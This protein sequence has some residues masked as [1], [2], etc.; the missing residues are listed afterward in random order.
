MYEIELSSAA[1]HD[2]KKIP[3]S[4]I[5]HINDAIDQLEI[6]PRPV[7]YKKLQNRNAYRVRAGNYRIIYEIND[8][9]LFILVIRIR[10]RSDV[11]KNMP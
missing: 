1:A 2:Y 9:E 7:G 5:E 10:Q 8:R 4:E 11:Y 6:N 3:N